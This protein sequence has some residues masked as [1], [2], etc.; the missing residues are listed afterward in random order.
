M[1]YPIGNPIGIFVGDALG[2]SAVHYS[3]PVFL[4]FVMLN[5]VKNS[6]LTLNFSKSTYHI[7]FL[8]FNWLFKLKTLIVF[9]NNFS[10]HRQLVTDTEVATLVSHLGAKGRGELPTSVYALKNVTAS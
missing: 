10:L 7:Y 8:F 2:Q 1:Q 6:T 3:I 4:Y 9:K 5:C